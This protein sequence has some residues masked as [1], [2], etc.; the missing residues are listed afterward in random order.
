MT[1][2]SPVLN[3]LSAAV[4][5]QGSVSCMASP[6]VGPGHPSFLPCSFTSQSFP[7]STLL[8]LSSALIIFFFCP[9]LPFCIR[10]NVTLWPWPLILD[11][12]S[13]SCVPRSNSVPNLSE[14]E[15][16]IRLNYW[17]FND[18]FFQEGGQ[19]ITSFQNEGG[20]K[21]RGVENRDQISP[22]LTPSPCKVKYKVR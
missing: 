5:V 18:D 11:F 22:L 4:G 7:L 15:Q 2:R 3:I 17:R 12:C 19:Y 16:S 1:T 21:T 8:F 20:S 14:T 13:R 10:Y 6:R 9:S